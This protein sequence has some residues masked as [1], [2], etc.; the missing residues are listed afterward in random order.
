MKFGIF[1]DL[2]LR[3]ADLASRKETV[4]QMMREMRLAGCS[5]VLNCGDTINVTD[6]KIA[7]G[8]LVAAYLSDISIPQIII[9][10]NH[11]FHD[12]LGMSGLEVF[13]CS[14]M[15]RI[16]AYNKIEAFD[17]GDVRLICLPWQDHL[18]SLRDGCENSPRASVDGC[19]AAI[20]KLVDNHPNVILIGHLGV[21]NASGDSG[22]ILNHSGWSEAWTIEDLQELKCQ[23]I[24]LGHYHKAQEFIG[25]IR[26]CGQ[27]QQNNFGE[28]TNWTGYWIWDSETNEATPHFL[29]SPAF[30]K[31]HGVDEQA[32]V[33]VDIPGE[34]HGR[35]WKR[36]DNK[37][38][39]RI[40][41]EC[42][43]ADADELK[44]HYSKVEVRAARSVTTVP[45]RNVVAEVLNKS[46][47]QQ[48]NEWVKC[49]DALPVKWDNPAALQWERRFEELE[50]SMGAL[51]KFDSIQRVVLKHIGPH[52]NTVIDFK[53]GYN[54][55]IGPNGT[56]KSFLLE[57]AFAALYGCW[58]SDGRSW[59]K[60]SRVE[61]EFQAGGCLYRV[62]RTPQA[63][64]KVLVEKFA[65][66]K[67]EE[68]GGGK[69]KLAD[70]NAKLAKVVGAQN[71]LR[72]C[73]YLEQFPKDIIGES[74][75][76]VRMAWMRDWLGFGAYDIIHAELKKART[77]FATVIPQINDYKD[78]LVTLNKEFTRNKEVWDKAKILLAE[79]KQEFDVASASLKTKQVELTTLKN[80]QYAYLQ[81][82]EQRKVVD[83]YKNRLQ[84][85]HEQQQKLAE[86]IDVATTEIESL[87][88]YKSR[89]RFIEI[90]DS[91]PN[92]E[93]KACDLENAGC[94]DKPIPCIF[95]QKAVEAQRQAN[96][97]KGELSITPW[98]AER[99]LYYLSLFANRET[100]IQMVQSQL[101]YQNQTNYVIEQ[102]EQAL[103]SETEAVSDKQIKKLE[104]EIALLE[105]D[106]LRLQESLL[107]QSNV[108]A[109]ASH[110]ME[111]S[112]KKIKEIEEKLPGLMANLEN[113]ET[114][115]TLLAATGPE[116]ICQDLIATALPA[117]QRQLELLCEQVDLPFT[118][119]LGTQRI[120]AGGACKETFQLTFNR[121]DNGKAY[122]V[123]ATSGG[124]RAVVRLLWRLAIILTRADGRYKVLL[125][126]EPTAANDEDYTD[127]IMQ[128]LE[129]TKDKFS[130]I[131][132]VTHDKNL[133]NRIDN[134][135]E[136]K[137][138]L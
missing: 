67:W 135:I 31:L 27:P 86:Q 19:K 91:L 82:L 28:A 15:I 52:T 136:L 43:K 123:R 7:L 108:S 107:T 118:I 72:G 50:N 112:G 6:K 35:M 46:F 109:V 47:R 1:A 103:L 117:I 44:Q 110:Q 71:T 61:L 105:V 34:P 131:I 101:T 126:D 88:G 37:L 13:R 12:S 10:G 94:K 69:S 130:Q 134:C 138:E 22:F 57:A 98:T 23:Q 39:L 51:G 102:M 116:G 56:G 11:D 84:L 87:E 32:D 2:H 8:D 36:S 85:S 93:R 40:E 97:L 83:E 100:V 125:L 79:I 104:R 92:F 129:Y 24:F 55:I 41:G 59:S 70:G 38:A 49:N 29:D 58:A 111:D 81:Q 65:E 42:S 99:E 16:V 64:V 4:K 20:K 115:S 76:G 89:E 132:M 80:K 75:D 106:R 74:D 48:V 53:D 63:T 9:E 66:G 21:V 14:P 77:P 127:A 18:R 45:E 137:K 121:L 114:I 95:T 26:Y 124:E 78:Q 33:W 96:I 113:V 90:R 133:S 5:W 120:T 30:L 128:L 3:E 68:F 122:D 54:C 73:S 62:T 25:N 17:I 60:D 119:T